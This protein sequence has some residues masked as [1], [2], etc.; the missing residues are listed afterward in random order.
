MVRKL[1][2][3]TGGQGNILKQ[4][5]EMQA[6][7]IAVQ[8]ELKNKTVEASVGGGA[9]LVKVNGQKEVLSVN[10]S[11]DIVKEAQ[12]DKE[13]LEDLILSAV[14]E[15]MRQAEELAEKEM[16]SVTGGINIPG[17]I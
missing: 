14:S 3:K 2:S 1:K 9:V 10:L 8:E 4:A 17:L 5:Q 13:M 15:A 7:M 16:G 12:E 11:N 6:R